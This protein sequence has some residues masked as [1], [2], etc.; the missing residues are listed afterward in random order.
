MSNERYRDREGDAAAR[1][2]RRPAAT[3]GDDHPHSTAH[4]L[5]AIEGPLTKLL[6]A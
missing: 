2:G 3:D 4:S 1:F 6:V 5:C